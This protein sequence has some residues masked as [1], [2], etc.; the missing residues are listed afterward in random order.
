[1]QN[2]YLKILITLAAIALCIVRLINPNIKV[3][4][5]LLILLGISV[6]PWLSS[7]V[8]SVE[9]PGG[10]KIEFQDSEPKVE[11]PKDSRSQLSTTEQQE[12]IRSPKAHKTASTSSRSKFIAVDDYF[13]RM[14]KLTPVETIAAFVV[15]NTMVMKAAIG[16]SSV[17]ATISW[18]VF[19]LLIVLTPIWILRRCREVGKPPAYRQIALSTLGFI[20]WVFALGGP[21]ALSSWYNPLYGAFLL[22]IYMVISPILILIFRD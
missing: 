8:K 15:I 19:V 2:T 11:F 17:I 20:V 9:L 10:L 14:V 4:S 7:L 16:S 3:D 22:A 18:L 5:T 1:M 6:L 12:I 21:F 13:D